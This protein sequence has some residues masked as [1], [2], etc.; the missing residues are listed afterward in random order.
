MIKDSYANC[1]VPF[2]IPSCRRIV[3]VD[4]RYF[5]DDIDALVEAEGVTDILLLYNANTLAS[6]TALRVDVS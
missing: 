5:T 2:M 1:F 3:M 6:D 4:P